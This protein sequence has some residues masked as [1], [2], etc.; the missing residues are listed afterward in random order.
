MSNIKELKTKIKKEG[1][2]NEDALGILK[3]FLETASKSGILST[4]QNWLAC[5]AFDFI[6]EK[7]N[8]EELKKAEK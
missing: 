5:E 4:D 2:N 6:E 8:S 3:G 1:M 7:F